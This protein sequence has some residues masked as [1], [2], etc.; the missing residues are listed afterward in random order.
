MG[1]S[2]PGFLP[3]LCIHPDGYLYVNEY[4]GEIGVKVQFYFEFLT[5]V[6][7]LIYSAGAERGIVSAGTVMISWHYPPQP[8]N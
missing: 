6:L 3:T 1:A 4:S 5:A 2:E 8:Q 7:G